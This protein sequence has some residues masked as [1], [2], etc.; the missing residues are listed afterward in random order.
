[1]KQWITRLAPSP[2][3]ELHIGNAWSFLLA[4]LYARSTGGKIYLRMDD[5][6]PQRSKTELASAIITDLRWLGLDWDNDPVYQR[7]R[8]EIYERALD[9]LSA[10]NLVYPCFCSRKELRQLAS[11]P[12]IG[13]EGAP[14]PGICANLDENE[15][16]ARIKAGRHYA[17]RLRC[18]DTPVAFNDLVYGEK[19]YNKAEYGGDFALMRSD[20]VWAYQLASACDDAE[21]GVNLVVRGR[22]LLAST[23]RQIV[24]GKYLNLPAVQYAHVPLLLSPE[25]ERLAKRHKSLSLKKLRENGVSPEKICGYLAKLAGMNPQGAP[26][27]PYELAQKFRPGMIPASDIAIQPE[28]LLN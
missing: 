19:I 6:D 11:A 13:D 9:R 23:P 20:G 25:G 22:D 21:M 4:W 18:P 24:V 28:K 17:L 1:M 12:H 26:T 2:T 3:G 8:S 14:Y 10:K 27:R 15:R 5:I 16:S 7:Q